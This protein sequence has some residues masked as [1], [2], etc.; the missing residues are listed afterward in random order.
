MTCL[1]HGQ[2]AFHITTCSFK[3]INFYERL[4]SVGVYGMK[5]EAKEV[6]KECPKCVEDEYSFLKTKSEL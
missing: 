6:C 1:V 2:L 3:V 5:Y 4:F